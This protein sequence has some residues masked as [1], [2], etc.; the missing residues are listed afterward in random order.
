MFR[1]KISFNM[2]FVWL[3]EHTAITSPHSS[4]LQFFVTNRKCV[5]WRL[6]NAYL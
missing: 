4:N 2:Y 5:Q 1:P 6:W 3:L